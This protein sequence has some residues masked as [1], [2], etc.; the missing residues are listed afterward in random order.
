V[1]RL[2]DPN[3][4]RGVLVELTKAGQ[5]AWQES[6]GAEAAREALIGAALSAHEKEQLN[7][8]LRRLMLEFE[9]HEGRPSAD[10]TAAEPIDPALDLGI[11]VHLK[12]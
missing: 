5:K 12:T 6:T 11:R 9:R 4:R 10:W 1:K 2:A 7:D 8:L 3:D